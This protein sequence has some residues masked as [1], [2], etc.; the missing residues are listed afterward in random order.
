MHTRPV[1]AIQ[2]G[3]RRNYIYAR[4]LEAAGLL[5]YLA[6]DAAWS[7]RWAEWLSRLAPRLA[8]KLR[9]RSI[10][11]VPPERIC[12]T[13]WPTLIAPLK[14]F[15]D[16]E[17]VFDL[18]DKALAWRLRLR[19]LRGATIVVNYFG[20]GGSFLD[21][22]KGR[23]ATVITDFISSPKLREIERRERAAW[24]GW[25][26]KVTS[27]R[28]I[29][30]YRRR[31]NWLLA[32]SDIYLC[33]S[34]AVVDDL[35]ELPGFDSARVRIVAYGTGGVARTEPQPEIGRVLF[36]GSGSVC[37][38]LPYL[39]QAASILRRQRPDINIFVAGDVSAAVCQRAETRDLNFLGHLNR[40]EMAREIARA[41][42][43]CFPSLSEGSATVIYEALAH[44]LPVITTRASGS[45][46]HDGIEGLIIPAR[47]SGAIAA[48]VCAI[49][50]DRD[51]RNAMSEAAIATASLH[52]ETHCGAAFLD[53]IRET[54]AS[55]QLSHEVKDRSLA[56]RT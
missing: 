10:G 5:N 42:V 24:P 27:T 17:I 49:V 20:N 50:G 25:D 47:D 29:D 39:A 36:A 14:R 41:D 23:G 35:A 13:V 28:A 40:E 11:G 22:A 38:G 7:S 48:A 3:A 37:K 54:I 19:G 26:S 4:Q 43:F 53:V 30:A 18:M 2:Q 16:D 1:I 56:R 46:V 31:F 32:I 44:G 15:V 34:Q 21:Y 55:T 51:R 52:G 9:R 45:V 33:P 12:A 8:G 6:C